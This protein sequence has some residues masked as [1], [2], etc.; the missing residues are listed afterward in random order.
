MSRDDERLREALGHVNA[1]RAE[2]LWLLGDTG[3][4]PELFVER[5]TPFWEEM[6]LAIKPVREGT[7]RYAIRDVFT[8]VNGSWELGAEK[9]SIPRW[10]VDDYGA[11][12]F[13]ERGAAHALFGAVLTADGG[14]RPMTPFLVGWPGES[15][16]RVTAQSG[17]AHENMYEGASY[18]P[19]TSRGVYWMRP[20]MV[21]AETLIN[22][23]RPYG[24]R[25]SVFCVWRGI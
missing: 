4:V 5:R 1:A 17:W 21:G 14:F 6:G 24:R 12:S 10:A 23:G 20:N 11:G 22:V 19:Q 15:V 8:T 13:V 3:D 2:L 25:V 18:N 7:T 16:L 9:F